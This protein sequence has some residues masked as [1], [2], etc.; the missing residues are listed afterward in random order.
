MAKD[1]VNKTKGHQNIA[2]EVLPI[3]K[4]IGDKYP[5]YTISSKS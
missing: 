2:K 4:M 5:I 1:A 3:L